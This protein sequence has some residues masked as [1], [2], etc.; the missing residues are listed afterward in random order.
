[1]GEQVGR[2]SQKKL[3]K[4]HKARSRFFIPLQHIPLQHI[5]PQHI[6]VPIFH[7]PHT[8]PRPKLSN[9]HRQARKAARRLKNLKRRE[10]QRWKTEQTSAQ[11]ELAQ[12]YEKRPDALTQ[13]NL[14][15]L[16]RGNVYPMC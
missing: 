1:L 2:A 6:S 13:A 4:Y 7:M 15:A 11:T 9:D 5:L 3:D 10:A 14:K 16:K 8:Q 12:A